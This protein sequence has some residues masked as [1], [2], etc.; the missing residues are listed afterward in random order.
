MKKIISLILLS[1]LL[2]TCNKPLTKYNSDFEGT[3]YS[4]PVFNT[5]YSEYVSDQF[6]FTGK[7]GSYKIDCRDT[8]TTNLCNCLGEI[9]G[10]S[11]INRQHNMI[12]LRGTA[13]RT[14]VLEAEPYQSANGTWMME[15]DG[16]TYIKQ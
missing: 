11:E 14:F 4:V 15:V 1:F 12:R 7:D 10:K 16:K 5:T 6:V 3:W 2:I 13:N 8:C 9:K